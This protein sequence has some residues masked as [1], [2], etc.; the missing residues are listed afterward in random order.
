VTKII[1]AYKPYLPALTTF[2]GAIGLAIGLLF[3]QSP[4]PIFA[5]MRFVGAAVVAI[6]TFWSGH[7]QV[8]SAAEARTRNEKIAQLTE[9]VH[10]YTSGGESFCHGYPL[11]NQER[12][13]FGWTF[14]HSGDYPLSEVSVR[15]FDMTRQPNEPEWTGHN[16]ALGTL[17]PGRA[18][19]GG[20][21]QVASVSHGFNLFFVARNGSWTQE[22]RWVSVSDT[23]VTANRVVRD[24]DPMDRP[25]LLEISPRFGS[26]LPSDNAWNN[27]PPY[28][29]RPDGSTPALPNNS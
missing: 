27:P 29:T 1:Q 26:P 25:L 14:I 13:A 22:I 28:E 23:F 3:I 17:F 12:T 16:Y 20:P 7:R 21:V 15:I 11:F 8:M 5:W 24:G 2:V 18:S 6:G 9:Q 19:G 10:G 4:H